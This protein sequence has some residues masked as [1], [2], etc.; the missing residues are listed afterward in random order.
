M[1]ECI[2]VWVNFK[3]KKP[4]SGKN[5]LVRIFG[6]VQ[7]HVYFWCGTTLYVEGLDRSVSL[8]D[9]GVES[10][11]MSWCYMPDSGE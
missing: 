9:K 4:K 2:A 5:I 7:L 3:E 11:N 8:Y 1:G 6:S 10:G